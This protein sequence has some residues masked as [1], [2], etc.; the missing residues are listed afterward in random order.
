MYQ[1]INAKLVALGLAET[2]HNEKSAQEPKLLH[3]YLLPYMQR[4]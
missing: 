2:E 3:F 1:Q 4:Q